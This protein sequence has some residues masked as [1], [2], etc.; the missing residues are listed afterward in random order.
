MGLGPLVKSVLKE[1]VEQL[2]E[3]FAI[4]SASAENYL[5]KQG[6]KPEELKFAKLGLPADKVTKADL[7]KAEQQRG[8]S[9]TRKVNE[10]NTYSYVTLK[11]EKE[12]P[13]YKEVVYKFNPAEKEEKVA[14][15]TATP[16]KGASVTAK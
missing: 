9:I 2:P 1:T 15:A 5:L 6:V 13:T 4:K 16:L 10:Q 12:N 14:T 11:G 8:G 7:V 3:D